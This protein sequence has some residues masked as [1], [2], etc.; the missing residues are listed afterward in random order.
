[1]SE[2][3]RLPVISRGRGGRPCVVGAG[4]PRTYRREIQRHQGAPER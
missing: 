1:M 4:L 3:Q 2:L